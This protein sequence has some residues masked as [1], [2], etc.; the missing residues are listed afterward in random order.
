MKRVTVILLGSLGLI[1]IGC[2]PVKKQYVP[3]QASIDTLERGTY[4]DTNYTLIIKTMLDT[5]ELESHHKY[6]DNQKQLY[7]KNY[8]NDSSGVM[9]Y[10]HYVDPWLERKELSK[11]YSWD[12]KWG[13]TIISIDSVFVRNKLKKVSILLGKEH[14]IGL[15]IYTFQMEKEYRSGNVYKISIWDFDRSRAYMKKNENFYDMETDVPYEY[16]EWDNSYKSIFG[17]VIIRFQEAY[18]T[19]LLRVEKRY[20]DLAKEKDNVDLTSLIRSL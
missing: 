1:L 14:Q 4:G 13:Q 7:I 19:A 5:I 3:I 11:A 9:R 17:R 10:A 15:D 6:F 8:Y 20:L 12:D 16:A 2:K 18:L